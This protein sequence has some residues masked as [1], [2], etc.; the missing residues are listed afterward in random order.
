MVGH[1]PLRRFDLNP[2]VLAVND[3]DDVWSA[4]DAG[5]EKTALV[6]SRLR[7]NKSARILPVVKDPFQREVVED[8]FLD[9]G[10][11]HWFGMKLVSAVT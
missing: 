8:L 1:F 7:K 10:F 11:F 3:A 4:E 2:Y 5:F 9:F 6:S